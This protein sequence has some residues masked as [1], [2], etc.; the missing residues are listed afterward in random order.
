M[1]PFHDRV[2]VITGAASGIGRALALALAAGGARVAGLDVQPE[3]LHTLAAQLD[4][5]PFAHAVAD[6]TDLAAVRAA[7]AELEA[8]LGPTDLLFAC[9]GIGRETA[10]LDFRAEELNAQVQVNLIGVINSV[11]AVLPGMCQRRRGH[12][13]VLSSLASYR[14]LPRMGGYCASKAGVNALFDALRAELRDGGV[15]FTTVCPG[16]IRTP[17]TAPLGLPDEELMEV[18]EAARRILAAVR[19]RRAFVAFPAGSAWQMWLLRHLPRRVGDWL[20]HR[21]IVKAI[22]RTRP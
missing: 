22:Q 8:R 10:A 13:V 4:G 15:S 6:V 12:L 20:A 19:A 17:M 21:F 18:D 2:A 3:G 9:A 14:G 7:V 11:G 1:G 5:N 16:W